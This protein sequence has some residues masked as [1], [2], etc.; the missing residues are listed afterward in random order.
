MTDRVV[1]SDVPRNLPGASYSPSATGI[2]PVLLLAFFI[3]GTD[4]RWG[5]LFESVG[6]ILRDWWRGVTRW[7][8]PEPDHDAL[9]PESEEALVAEELAEKHESEVSAEKDHG[10]VN[11]PHKSRPQPEETIHG[12]TEAEFDAWWDGASEDEKKW[13][14]MEGWTPPEGVTFNNT[15]WHYWNRRA[16]ARSRKYDY[17]NVTVP[18]G[19]RMGA[20]GRQK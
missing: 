9:S 2:R 6:R 8:M 10:V 12:W 4:M 19:N 18:K 14:H 5:M 1:N 3:Q 11:N 15:D 16:L 20:D 17:R 7:A 13:T